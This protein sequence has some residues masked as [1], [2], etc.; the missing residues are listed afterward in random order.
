MQQ[1]LEQEQ[2]DKLRFIRMLKT[3]EYAIKSILKV[4]IG[5]RTMNQ[6]FYL[7]MHLQQNV[8]FFQNYSG[9]TLFN[10][11]DQVHQ[12]VYDKGEI[13]FK[14]GDF[15]DELIVVMVGEV[16]VYV[17]DMLQQCVAVLTENKTY[18]E[19][20]VQQP[21]V[22]QVNLLAHRVTVCLTLKKTD[23]QNQVFHMEHMQKIKRLDY[24]QRIYIFKSWAPENIK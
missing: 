17:D 19:R 10:L 1:Q 21:E 12:R 15:G 6:R 4:A 8:S 23:F 20:S 16:G 11:C 22:R 2:G 13:I 5:Q 9:K 14:K 18:G 24:L 7:A 3:K